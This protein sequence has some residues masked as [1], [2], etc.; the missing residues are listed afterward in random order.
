MQTDENGLLYMRARYYNPMTRRFINADPIGFE[1]GLNWYAYAG[2]DP[3]GYVDPTGL[4]PGEFIVDYWTD[5]IVDPSNGTLGGS[6]VSAIEGAGEGSSAYFDGFV[7]ILDPLQG[8]YDSDN[9]LYATIHDGAA[10]TREGAIAVGGGAFA[11]SVIAS[12]WEKVLLVLRIHESAAAIAHESTD[13]FMN[14]GHLRQKV[15]CGMSNR[16]EFDSSRSEYI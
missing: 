1:G 15:H 4:Y 16:R 5:A 12:I 7:P 11:Q 8:N 2:G 14:P 9:A 10:L 13:S 6:I 3:L